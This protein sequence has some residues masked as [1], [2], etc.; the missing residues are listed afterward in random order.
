MNL[1]CSGA[2]TA[3]RQL[4][5]PAALLA[6]A[7]LVDGCSAT[8]VTPSP[9]AQPTS[10]PAPS[11]T[12]RVSPSF[13]PSATPGEMAPVGPAPAGRWSGIRW[14]NAGAVF[15]QQPVA[16]TDNGSYLQANVF[17]W[18]RGYVGFR[19]A[20][21][22]TYSETG[23]SA[24][25]SDVMVSTISADGIHW[26][27]GRALDI[28]SLGSSVGIM[29][30]VE[31]PAGLLAAGSFPRGVCGGP[32]TVD[33]LWSSPDGLTWTRV[34]PPADFVS[35]S[36][37]T[38]DAGSAGY[39]ATGIL[40]DG[41][42]AAVWV[43]P[44]GRSWHRAPL[45]KTTS[46]TVLAHGATA[47]EGGFLISGARQIQVGCGESVQV[48]SVWWSADAKSW[49][50]QQLPGTTAADESWV[51]VRRI[52][53]H[54]VMATAWVWDATTKASSQLVWASTDGRTWTPLEWPANLLSASI[55]PNGQRGLAFAY[56]PSDFAGPAIATIDDAL[57][58]T[59]LTPSG[60]PPTGAAMS[61]SPVAFGPTGVVV[62]TNDGLTLW[63]GV[64][65]ES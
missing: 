17:G 6:V 11:A 55:L 16:G 64:P 51:D 62:L 1:V 13:S 34:R 63:L 46:G 26:T 38:L 57:T 35:A 41:A 43:S 53:D 65:I 32:A 20:V 14:I 29:T 54:A 58:I 3:S 33:V 25:A 30:V 21:D 12:I 24:I 56:P 19:T 52:S 31:G 39:I 2:S 42:T 50:A 10:S 47:F 5:W 40:K 48:P 28:T 27:P 15:P 49:T 36:V 45:P 22:A 18:S 44:D 9:S 8:A 61:G 37:Y 60:D 59:T 4:T 7:C 23:R